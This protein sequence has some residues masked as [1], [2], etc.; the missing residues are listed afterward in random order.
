[1][2]GIPFGVSSTGSLVDVLSEIPDEVKGYFRLGFARICKTDK[3][4]WPLII[5]AISK[6]SSPHTADL[7]IEAIVPELDIEGDELNHLVNSSRLLFGILA[8]RTE[9]VGEI[10]SSALAAN[11]LSNENKDDI[12][13]FGNVAAGNRMGLKQTLSLASLQH[14]LLPSLMELEVKVDFRFG[15]EGDKVNRIAPV[16]L[17]HL[18]TDA[19]NQ[20]VWFQLTPSQVEGVIA[21]LEQALKQL[22]AAGAL[23]KPLTPS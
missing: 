13:A 20:E 14:A 5:S 7:E 18:D 11:I 16:V 1:M 19:I 9:S 6:I 15:F 4:R 10:I 2:S 17:V 23:L 3:A 22:N 21:R 12:V 8:F